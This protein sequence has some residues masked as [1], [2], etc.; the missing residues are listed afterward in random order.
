MFILVLDVIT[1]YAERL[2]FVFDIICNDSIELVL[3]ILTSLE[4]TL[5]LIRCEMSD[6]FICFKLG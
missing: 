3:M 4:K 5:F 1:F 2:Y 6:G